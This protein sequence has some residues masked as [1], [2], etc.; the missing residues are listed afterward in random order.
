MSDTIKFKADGVEVEGEKG[1]SLLGVLLREG[2]DIPHLC[3]HEAV[4]A[5]GA[6]RLCLVEIVRHGRR[7]IATSCNYPVMEGIEVTTDSDKIRR[8]R[9]VTMELHLACT[10]AS[11]PLKR[12]AAD[13]GV[14]KTRFKSA[15]PANDCILCGLC[16]RVCSEIVDV[17]A[18][19]FNRRGGDKKLSPPFMEASQDCIA[20]GACVFVCPSRCIQL[21]QSAYART[22]D[23]W[24]RVAALVKS[25]KSKIAF[26]PKPQLEYFARLVGLPADF[27]KLAPGE[28]NPEHE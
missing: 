17:H 27:Y 8:L 4:A 25:E 19:G 11:A 24:G 26:A 6:C 16:E 23:R 15:D 28:R 12:M 3:F 21:K 22:I 20:C 7:R 18:I 13:M 10:P 2:F 1:A 5:Y 14:M 9:R